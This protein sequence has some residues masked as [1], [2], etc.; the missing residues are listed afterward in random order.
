MSPTGVHLGS[1]CTFGVQDLAGGPGTST[2]LAAAAADLSFC[3]VPR[4]AGVTGE[5]REERRYS[6][7]FYREFQIVEYLFPLKE[8]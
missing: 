7:S 8:G 4:G 5:N 6:I 1:L 3:R 2:G